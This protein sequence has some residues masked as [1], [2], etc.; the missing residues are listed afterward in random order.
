MEQ[1]SAIDALQ[2][3]GH[4]CRLR[5]FR[6]LVRQG[7]AGLAAGG[8]ADGLGIA[9]SSLSFHLDRLERAGLI[10]SERRG[11]QVIYRINETGMR[12]LLSYLT[13]DCC[14]GKPALCGDLFGRNGADTM[15][16]KASAYNV[17]FLCTGNSARSIIAE[18]IL[19]RLGAGR[20][21]AYSA[22]SFPRGEVHPAVL[23]LLREKGH[24]VGAL[25]S[26]SWD[27][28][29]GPSAPRMDLVFTVCDNAASETCPVWPGHPMTVHW[30]MPDP[31]AVTGTA[32]E[33]AAAFE[34]TYRAMHARIL[35]LTALP[36][37]SLD[38]RS[39]RKRLLDIGAGGYRHTE[40]TS[41]KAPA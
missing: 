29:T 11:R 40:T 28:F 15:S 20:F 1:S 16:S 35:A 26:K 39:L 36:M 24:D 23:Q 3:L 41:S 34:D 18:C 6:I 30:G 32:S 14:H 21:R 22:G 9:P 10:S 37:A 31:A 17:L 38:Q 27:D 13:E 12:S 2:A 19:N 5:V 7:N 4:A 25:R 33:V 8:I